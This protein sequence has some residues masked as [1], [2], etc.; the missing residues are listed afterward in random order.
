MG[1]MNTEKYVNLLQDQVFP[2]LQNAI[3]DLRSHFFMQD[4]ASCHISLE[5]IAM[6]Y[7]QFDYIISRRCAPD[8]GVEW[9]ARSCDLNPLD[10]YLWGTWKGE[11]GYFPSVEFMQTSATASLQNIPLEDIRRAIDRFPKCVDAC[12]DADGGHFVTN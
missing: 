3:P 12:F 4:G 6:I 1:A 5:S 2:A 8:A 9:P 7:S 11:M 10:Y